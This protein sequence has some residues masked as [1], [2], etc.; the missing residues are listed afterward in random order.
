MYLQY[1]E[2]NAEQDSHI[3]FP[4]YASACP[5][6]LSVP[7]IVRGGRTAQLGCFRR[8]SVRSCATSTAPISRLVTRQ[9]AVHSRLMRDPN[10]SGTLRVSY[11]S[12]PL[13]S[14]L[15]RVATSPRLDQQEPRTYHHT[16]PYPAPKRCNTARVSEN[17]RS[18]DAQGGGSSL[19]P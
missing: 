2:K 9:Y 1:C 14:A 19:R 16:P 5:Y 7:V 18:S 10:Q 17:T 4:G 8:P 6:S 13:P 11:L 3:Q 15:S 12:C